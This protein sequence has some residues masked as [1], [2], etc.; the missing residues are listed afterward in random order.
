M[1]KNP[2]LMQGLRFAT[3]TLLAAVV[4]IA[5]V[6]ITKQSDTSSLTGRVLLSKQSG[7]VPTVHMDVSR[8]EQGFTVPAD[9]HTIFTVPSVRIPRI[10][11]LGA[12]D[13]DQT[14]RYWGYCFSGNEAANKAAGKT[15]SAMYDGRFF[16]SLAERKAQGKKPEPPSDADLLGILHSAADE[17]TEEPASIAEI[18]NAG[19]TCYV[20]SERELPAGIDH[21]GDDLND[22]REQI[23][24]TDP[25]NTDTDRDGIADGIETL[26][27]KT[28][29]LDPDTDHDGLGDKLEDSNM[30]GNV[31]QGETSPRNSD[32]DRDQLCD[33]NGSAA[34]CPEQ[35][36]IVCTSNGNGERVCETRPSSPVHG[37]DM[38][39]NGEVDDGET[40]PTDPDTFGGINDWNYKWNRFQ[41]SLEPGAQ[42]TVAPD[43]PIP[44]MPQSTR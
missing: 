5:I 15:G 27:T 31:E 23:L 12:Q 3:L 6:Y 28:A 4:V 1:H 2:Y 19:D 44:S 38:N 30:N 41:G 14:I 16:Y 11:F 33:G 43:F 40:D 29:P 17:E 21:D 9:T 36:Q 7:S 37:E 34:A 26:V 20:M 22:K 10:T 32:T 42:G 18:F 25:Q 8:A 39:Q 13:Y 35:K 24:G